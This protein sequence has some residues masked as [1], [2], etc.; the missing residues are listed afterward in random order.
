MKIVSYYSEFLRN[1]RERR[2]E[3]RRDAREAST[4]GGRGFMLGRMLALRAV[5]GTR[6]LSNALKGLASPHSWHENVTAPSSP[7]ASSSFSS[8]TRKPENND[9]RRAAS[10]EAKEESKDLSPDDPANW[11]G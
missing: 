9:R 6:I 11:T 3:R 5:L 2:R 1:R 7:S 4:F 10:T 8:G